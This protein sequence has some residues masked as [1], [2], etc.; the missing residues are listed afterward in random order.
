MIKN[1][2]AHPKIVGKTEWL[3]ARKT[4]L[5]HEK[6]LTKHHDRVNAERRRLP[7]VKLEKEYTFEEPNGSAKLI[8]L[9]VGRTQLIIYH[10]MFAPEWEKGCM[11][12]T[13]FVNALGD[14]SMLNERDTTFVL[15]SRAPLPKLE[16]YKQ[17]KGWTVP[18]YSSSGSDFNYDFHVTLDENITPIQYNYRDKA[19]LTERHGPNVM[20]GE[21]HGL[22]VF[23]RIDN[24]VFHTYSTYARGVE[25]LTDTYSLLD[26]T[27][28]GRQEDFED[29]PPGWPQRPTYG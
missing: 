11:G 19:E 7:M 4:L 8:D 12:C 3:T 20:Q 25:S 24:D 16:A 23:F 22:S 18:W 1:K 17:L 28:Y 15:V 26:V 21:S 27:P 5:E 13:G 10:F 14:L 29:S 2:I 6:E 9:F